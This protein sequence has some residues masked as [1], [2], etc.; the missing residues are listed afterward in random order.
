M[1]RKSFFKNAG[2][3]HS[4][5][6]F[7]LITILLAGCASN[8]VGVVNKAAVAAARLSPSDALSREL[9]LSTMALLDE[10]K[11]D[12]KLGTDDILSVTI[13]E[14]L[15]RDEAKTVEVRV[16]ETGFIHLPLIGSLLVKDQTVNGVEEMIFTCLT[17]GGFIKQPRIS[18][19]VKDF[20]S[21]SVAVVGAVVKPGQ[22]SLRENVTTLLDAL[23]L[24]GGMNER[25]GYELYVVR[26]SNSIKDVPGGGIIDDTKAALTEQ[27]A[28]LAA[29][30]R[31]GNREVMVIDM[32]ELLQEGNL[33]LNVVLTDGNV[34][35]VPEA[36]LFYV[37]GFV[38]KPGG[39]ALKRPT[40]VLEGVALAEGLME[41]EASPRDCALKR[42]LPNGEIVIPLD[43][44]A[45]SEGES[46]N[47]YLTPNDIIDVRQTTLRKV[48]LETFEFFKRLF[49][50][51]YNLDFDED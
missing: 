50:I 45:I 6:F 17:E 40:T 48:L 44:V 46:P 38:R 23:S 33:N 49:H 14:W 22:Y 20:R 31:D 32:I 12:Y 37:L 25:A 34:V 10:K 28:G 5:I 39:F 4:F 42:K 43:L 36:P 47:L 27:N 30:A 2:L 9:A 24:A 1:S 18:V 13:F 35:F 11:Q 26:P 19:L 51:G 7:V 29:F 41:G 8:E 16:S 15:V 21:K 3:A